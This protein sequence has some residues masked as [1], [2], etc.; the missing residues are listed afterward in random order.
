MID[1]NNAPHVPNSKPITERDFALGALTK[2]DYRGDF[3]EIMYMS[4]DEV[5]S[6]DVLNRKSD[7]NWEFYV[8][9]D[10]THKIWFSQLNGFFL[11]AETD[12]IYMCAVIPKNGDAKAIAF[13]SPNEF[14]QEVKGKSYKVA[15]DDDKYEIDRWHRKCT[16]RSVADIVEEIFKALDEER[17]SDVKG[18][19][20]PKTLY[21]L[22]EV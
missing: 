21:V 8:N 22:K 10:K 14:W 5:V 13:M 15:I 16:G 7:F 12:N 18:M 6:F 17:Y 11:S 1:F 19:T 20:K 3:S 9:G 4:H 2:P